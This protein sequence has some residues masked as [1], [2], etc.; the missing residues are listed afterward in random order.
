M[1][2]LT[3]SLLNID[4]ADLTIDVL[5]KLAVLSN[6]EWQMQL[7]LVDNGSRPDQVQR[8]FEWVL[9]NKDRFMEVLFVTASRNTGACLKTLDLS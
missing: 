4:E 5:D 9:A 2:Q 1:R 6:H 7:I 3:A 8:L